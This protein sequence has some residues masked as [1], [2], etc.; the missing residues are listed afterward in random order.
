MNITNKIWSLYNIKFLFNTKEGI[1]YD[2]Y[3][4]QYHNQMIH[5][6]ISYINKSKMIN[7]LS[8]IILYI[9][10]ICSS[11]ILSILYHQNYDIIII[12]TR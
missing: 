7:N 5:Y 4:Q 12:Y 3:N 1:E 8:N 9:E 11:Y 2:E 10:D 6:L